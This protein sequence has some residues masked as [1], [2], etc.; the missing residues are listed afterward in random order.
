MLIC[1]HHS[2]LSLT[3]ALGVWSGYLDKVQTCLKRFKLRKSVQGYLKECLHAF[4]EL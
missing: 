1:F 2:F 3:E 4:T